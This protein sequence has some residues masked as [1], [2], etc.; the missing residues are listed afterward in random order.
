MDE[1]ERKGRV[2][3]WMRMKMRMMRIKMKLTIFFMTIQKMIRMMM[4]RKKVV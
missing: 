1:G 2:R 4:E 3:E